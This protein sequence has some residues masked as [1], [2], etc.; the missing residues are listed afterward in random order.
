MGCWP[1]N[2]FETAPELGQ[3]A[4]TWGDR[5]VEE[6]FLHWC[7]G[8]KNPGESGELIVGMEPRSLPSI[9]VTPLGDVDT[10]SLEACPTLI[11]CLQMEPAGA[12]Q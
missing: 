10:S 8:E 3:L 11:R 7:R 1:W 6:R 2:L 9:D 4:L 5:S 12:S